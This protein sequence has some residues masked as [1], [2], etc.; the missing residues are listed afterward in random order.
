METV[1]AAVSDPPYSTG[2]VRVGAEWN[3]WLPE[4][5]VLDMSDGE[6]ICN[7]LP[8]CHVSSISQNHFSALSMLQTLAFD[9]S[10]PSSRNNT[11]FTQDRKELNAM[12]HRPGNS[13]PSRPS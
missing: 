8:Y 9:D 3:G 1:I 11:I 12:P 6:K 10:I 7:H 4:A 13:L 2:S 5:P